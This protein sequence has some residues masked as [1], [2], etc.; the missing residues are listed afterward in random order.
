MY[1]TN[2]EYIDLI[3]EGNFV[4]ASSLHAG[5][6]SESEDTKA[7]FDRIWDLH[8]LENWAE[9]DRYMGREYLG[10]WL[11][12]K[13]S[14]GELTDRTLVFRRDFETGMDA[15]GKQLDRIIRGKVNSLVEQGEICDLYDIL[16]LCTS[17]Y[18]EFGPDIKGLLQTF[19][20]YYDSRHV[21]YIINTQY[22]P[23]IDED[24]LRD[25]YHRSCDIL[26]LN[27]LI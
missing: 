20:D 5:F 26:G 2:D 23:S 22:E 1:D 10:D 6:F 21:D 8:D 17:R 14:L 18:K 25:L 13:A 19:F 7:V 15:S 9:I 11:D 16:T 27:I 24:E 3:I 4:D 12:Y